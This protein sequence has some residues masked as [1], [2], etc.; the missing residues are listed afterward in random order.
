MKK[1]FLISLLAIL[2]SCAHSPGNQQVAAQPEKTGYADVSMA[3]LPII[4]AHTH[5]HFTGEPEQTSGIPD[6]K[7]EYIR[8]MRAAGVVGAVSHTSQGGAGYFPELKEQGVVFCYGVRDKLDAA[9]LEQALKSKKY[10]CVKIYLGYAHHFAYEPLYRPAYKLAEKYNV[11][12]VFHT[13]DTYSTKAKIKYSDPM[14]I[15]EVAVDFPKTTF[16]IAHL[17]NPWINTATEVAYK[18]PNVYVEASAI[19]IG[20]LSKMTPQAFETQLVA[21]IRWAFQYMENPDKMMFGTD[22]PLTGM[23]DYIAAYKQAIPQKYWCKVFFENAVKVFHMDEL[24]KKY[25]CK[26]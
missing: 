2:T 20:D 22:W 10:G 26:N 19:M 13:G 17:G 11:P 3:D 14:A 6:T 21:P 23:K 24:K 12:V 8:E 16:V 18:N 5:T 25:H 7:E 9:D 4:D 15:D 1:I